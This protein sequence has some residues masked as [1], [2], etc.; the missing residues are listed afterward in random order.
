MKADSLVTPEDIVAALPTSYTTI[1]CGEWQECE[2]ELNNK[3]KDLGFNEVAFNR[4][5]L[6][7]QH[8]LY[9]KHKDFRAERETGRGNAGVHTK[10]LYCTKCSTLKKGQKE[11]LPKVLHFV[12]VGTCQLTKTHPEEGSDDKETWKLELKQL[13]PHYQQCTRQTTITSM[14]RVDTWRKIAVD[15]NFLT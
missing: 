12:V 3:L 9:S 8:P 11:P 7:K 2:H 10:N 6:G 4:L 14:G 5:R 15:L 13:F 1:V